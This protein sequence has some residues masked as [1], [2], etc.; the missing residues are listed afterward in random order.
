MSLSEPKQ[1]SFLTS[2]DIVASFTMDLS[3][4]KIRNQQRRQLLHMHTP[5]P[6]APPTLP[7]VLY[8]GT[9]HHPAYQNLTVSLCNGTL[10]VDFL[11]RTL[12]VI[13]TLTHLNKDVFVGESKLSCAK[14]TWYSKPTWFSIAEFKF[15]DQVESPTENFDLRRSSPSGLAIRLDDSFEP[16]TTW[17]RLVSFATSNC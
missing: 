8:T 4:Q 3:E 13:L 9:Y 12:P 5:N 11:N 16:T 7:L 14:P 17:F 10:V 15:R 2:S 6:P 1:T